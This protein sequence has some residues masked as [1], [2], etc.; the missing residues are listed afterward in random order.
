VSAESGVK[1][2]EVTQAG[3]RMGPRSNDRVARWQMSFLYPELS[4]GRIQFGCEV[5]DPRI[6]L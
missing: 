5:V 6:D 1:L 2:L 4:V 3:A